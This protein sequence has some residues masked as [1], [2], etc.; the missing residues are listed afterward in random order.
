[1]EVENGGGVVGRRLLEDTNALLK[2]SGFGDRAFKSVVELVSSVSSMCVALYER[3][4]DLRLDDVIREPRTVEDYSHNAQLIVDGLSAAL[5]TEDLQHVTG[6]KVCA[7]DLASISELLRVLTHVYQ[8]LHRPMTNR[9]ASSASSSGSEQIALDQTFYIKKPTKKK[10]QSS[11][12]KPTPDPS[13]L[14]TQKYGRFVPTSSTKS[15]KSTSTANMGGGAKNSSSAGRQSAKAGTS[16]HRPS[17]EKPASTRKAKSTP[18]KVDQ[19][20]APTRPMMDFGS[21]SSVS[22]ASDG[23]RD[24]VDLT[25]LNFST[26]SS[27]AIHHQHE[28]SGGILGDPMAGSSGE[29]QTS[30]ETKADGGSLHVDDL[31]PPEPS[32]DE[33]S[34]DDDPSGEMGASSPLPPTTPLPPGIS[35]PKSKARPTANAAPMKMSALVHAMPADKLQRTRYKTILNEHVLDMRLDE[36]KKNRHVARSF[37]H[38]KHAERVERIRTMKLHEELKLQRLALGVQQKRVEEKNLKETMEHLLML[39]KARLR[40]EHE[41]TA[42][43]LHEIQR[44]HEQRESALEHFF[45]KQM[46]LVKEQREHEVRERTLVQQAHKMASEQMLRELRGHREKEV[47]ALMEQRQHFAEVQQVRQEQ[48]LARFMAQRHQPPSMETTRKKIDPFYAAAM[49]SRAKRHQG[50]QPARAFGVRNPRSLSSSRDEIRA[51]GAPMGLLTI[52]KKVKQK[53]KEVRILLLGLDNAGKTTILKKFMGQDI[54]TIS[55]TLGFDIHTLEYKKFKLNV[56]DVGGQQTIRSYWRNY[57]EQT[58]GL[59][60]VVDSADRRRLEDCKR[61]LAALLTQEKLAGATLLI[62]ANKQD[63]PGALSPEDIVLALGLND[64]QFANRHWKIQSCSAFTGDGLVDGID[65][66]VTDIANRIYMLE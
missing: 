18:P 61:E 63:L 22:F 43:V 37:E 13:L 59:V 51:D 64:A 5:L 55:P 11:T 36:L 45:S 3:F 35:P 26:S 10:K 58:D 49:K 62:F 47:E 14:A 21:V 39:E 20:L 66:M 53:E 29:P 6:A 41:Q 31:A 8:M 27:G 40:Q 19:R 24:D 23:G 2:I 42:L 56:W 4:F 52:L 7:G 1:M 48:K 9:L 15:F 38:K 46:E 65:W 17:K 57:F 44:E 33:A 54:T 16:L 50:G 30:N 32:Q 12:P 34:P 25:G 60:W 28:L